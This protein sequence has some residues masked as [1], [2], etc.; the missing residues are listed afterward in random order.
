M[1]V[2]SILCVG[3]RGLTTLRMLQ[4]AINSTRGRRIHHHYAGTELAT[5]DLV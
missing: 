2:F 3:V 4:V 1:S 5:A